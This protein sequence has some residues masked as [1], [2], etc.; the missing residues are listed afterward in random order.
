MAFTAAFKAQTTYAS[1]KALIDAKGKFISGASKE[2]GVTSA[3]GAKQALPAQY[4][5]WAHSSAEGFTPSH[6]GPCEVW[7]D[8]KL[9]FSNDNCPKNYATAP[10][11]LP[12]DKSKCTGASM[13]KFYWLALHSDTWQAY[14]GCAPLSGGSG[15]TAAGGNGGDASSPV[16]SPTPASGSKGTPSKSPKPTTKGKK[17]ESRGLDFDE[18]DDAN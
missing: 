1:L 3:T 10:A 12:Y 7:C 17:R 16:V 11:K 2:C 9:A 5:E 18:L 14:I 4:V 13:L 15:G 6:Q 8:N